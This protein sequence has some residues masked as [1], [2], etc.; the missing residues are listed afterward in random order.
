[1][2]ADIPPPIELASFIDALGRRVTLELTHSGLAAIL[3]RTPELGLRGGHPALDRENA[4]ELGTALI[5]FAN[6]KPS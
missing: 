2:T 4:L 1:M 3:T 6:R 5:E